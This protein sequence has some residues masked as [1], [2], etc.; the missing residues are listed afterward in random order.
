MNV[1]YKSK[2]A[3]Q[4]EQGS[5]DIGCMDYYEYLVQDLVENEPKPFG[6]G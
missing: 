6:K 2:L 3:E 5:H 1:Y 4:I